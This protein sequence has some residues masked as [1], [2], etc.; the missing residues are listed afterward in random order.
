MFL[1]N[2]ILSFRALWKNKF[3]T[4]LNILGLSIGISACLVIYLIVDH[5]LSFN[6]H[7]PER[8]RIFRIHS[9]FTGSFSGINRG[10]FTGTAPFVR[11]NFKGVESV[12]LFVI[13]GSNVEVPK[14]EGNFK[15]QDRQRAVIASTNFFEV[16]GGYEWIA[17]SPAVLSKPSQVVITNSQA[18][19][20]FGTDDPNVV[21][22][23]HIIYRDS[24]HTT[25]GG[26]IADP[27]VNTDLAFTEFISW[28]TIEASWLKNDSGL[29][30]N[31]W[32]S[33]SSATQVFVR[34][35]PG[36]S[37]S[38]LRA[39]LPLLSKAFSENST[40]KA[41]NEFGVQPLNDLHYNAELG[42]FDFSGAPAHLPTLMTMIGVGLTLLIIA[43]INFINLS[44]AQ[45]VARA[46]EVGVRKVM[47]STRLKLIFQFL[48]E[49]MTLT[50]ISV[51]LSLPLTLIALNLFS[52]FIPSDVSLNVSGILPFI[53][54][55]TVFIGVFASAYPAFVLSSFMPALALKNQSSLN[56]QSRSAFLRKALIVF[57]FASAQ[58]LII[59][60][61]V[62]GSQIQ[63]L[64]NKDLG[65]NK[66]AVV[67]FDTPYWEKNNRSALL[68]NDLLQLPQVKEVALSDDPPSSNGW[69]STSVSYKNS[70]EEV[71]VT[72]YLKFG[73]TD[74]IDFYNIRILAGR[75]LSESDTVKEAVINET[76]MKK[77]GIAS[78]RE[79]IGEVINF[80]DT[81]IAIVGVV[82]DFHTQSLHRT[83][84]P[85]MMANRLNTFRCLNVRFS[86]DNNTGERLSQS[87]ASVETV[88]KKYYP[89][90]KFTYTFLEDTIRNYYLTEQRT[91]KLSATATALAIFISCLGLFGLASFTTNQRTK[92][93][94]IRKVLGASVKEI[95]M[96]LSRDF[97][98]LVAIA[99]I[100][101]IPLAW[102]AA[103]Q[104]LTGF[105]YR[106]NISAWLF[107]ATGI[108]AAV[109]AFITVSFQTTHAARKNPVETLRNE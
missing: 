3:H 98:V 40:W 44:T 5:E 96:L 26:I 7:I 17:G 75:N 68:K 90:Q 70:A 13:F 81:P 39:Q 62:I 102:Q 61:L 97:L 27:G 19:R 14:A 71:S 18:K 89:D 56:N 94:G 105:S 41:T 85:V 55:V 35:L 73:D 48:T 22:G 88:W 1:H 64:L 24:L 52:E 15:S 58:I 23:N 91:A 8:E 109:L 106:T 87:L 92:E 79:A 45:S 107:A 20:Y 72:T 49:G 99:F 65:F 2:L 104:W 30:E 103:E 54:G 47:G 9:K 86:A 28:P 16:F 63:F 33:I 37:E 95:V 12:T 43:A 67:Y 25:V 53:L 77:L 6:Q 57:Q 83:I 46:R 10:T 36:T 82:A 100:I 59:G 108:L 42:I 74:Y 38:E 76:L 84:E 69:S 93:I 34:M 51:L 80:G 31:S 4:V 66:E 11:D 78:A 101:A 21:L 32:S 50:L 60:S 29:K